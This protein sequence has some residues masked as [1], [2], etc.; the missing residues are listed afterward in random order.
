[1]KLLKPLF[2]LVFF[3]FLTK[4]IS[5]DCKYPKKMRKHAQKHLESENIVNATKFEVTFKDFNKVGSIHFAKSDSRYFMGL[6]FLRDFSRKID[7][8]LDNPFIFKLKNDSLVTLYPAKSAFDR[9]NMGFTTPMG[10]KILKA[11]YELSSEQLQ[12]FATNPI[13]NTKLYVT[14]KKKA[15]NGDKELE[16]FDFDIKKEKWQSNFMESAKCI[17]Q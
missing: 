9:G 10:T 17:L 6:I 2:L 4:G 7:V 8:T 3:F 11:Y 16:I 12:L 5:Q 1:M 13:K 15:K 14:L